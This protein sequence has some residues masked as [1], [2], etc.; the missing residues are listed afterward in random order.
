MSQQRNQLRR[1]ALRVL[2]LCG[3][4]SLARVVTGRMARI[5]MYHNFTYQARGNSYPVPISSLR[6]QFLYLKR[7]FRVV[8]LRHLIDRLKQGSRF[9]DRSVAITIDDGRRNCFDVLFPLL[10][11]FGFPAT[12]YVV[13]SFINEEIWIWTDKVLWL[14]E[15]NGR[16]PYLRPERLEALFEALNKLRPNER[17]ACI[18]RLASS[19]GCRIPSSPPIQYAPCSWSELR[20]MS[21]SG[22]VEIGSHSVSHPIFS[23]ISD[24]ESWNELSSS[25]SEIERR[26][27]HEVRSFCFP[28]GKVGDYRPSQ[29]EQVKSAGYDNAVVTHFGLV[30]SSTGCFELPRIGVAGQTEAIVFAKQVDGAEHCQAK[31]LTMKAR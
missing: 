2:K 3:A 23:S 1:Q 31:L 24:E 29:I 4:F 6:S 18:E 12:F 30:P 7:H 13:S 8:P 5:L 27:G 11:E 15:Q 14:S 9:D 20:Q 22:L 25:R 28:N 10:R 26:V 19:S 21:D 17:D 16:S